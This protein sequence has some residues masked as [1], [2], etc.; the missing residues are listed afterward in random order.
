M[1]NKS[2]KKLLVVSRKWRSKFE[3]RNCC[4]GFVAFRFEGIDGTMKFVFTHNDGARPRGAEKAD[5]DGIHVWVHVWLQT[6][7]SVAGAGTKG[8]DRSTGAV[9]RGQ[10]VFK[11]TV[12][13]R[14]TTVP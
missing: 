10:D 12:K 9:A 4:I 6:M 8:S 3:C 11:G 14:A 2:F 5:L 13:R 7:G 1:E